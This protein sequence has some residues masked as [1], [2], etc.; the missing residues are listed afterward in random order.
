MEEVPTNVVLA[1]M[2]GDAA[3]LIAGFNDTL[4]NEALDDML[5]EGGMTVN[6]ECMGFSWQ[7]VFHVTTQK[8]KKIPKK[9]LGVQVTLRKTIDPPYRSVV[10]SGVNF[11]PH[12]R[13][14]LR[15][16]ITYAQQR[17]TRIKTKGVCVPCRA[18]DYPRT[19]LAI[20]KTKKCSNCILKNVL[21]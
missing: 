18:R 1:P 17:V 12:T 8:I 19:K 20:G 16:A 7:C 4:S 9:T 3:D 13:D 2:L 10:V 11:L 15:K 6:G 21:D 5:E 14:G